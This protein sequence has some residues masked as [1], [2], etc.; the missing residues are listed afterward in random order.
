MKI[1]EIKSNQGKTKLIVDGYIYGCEKTQKNVIRWACEYKK[2]HLCKGRVST[3]KLQN[4]HKIIKEPS[5]HNHAPEASRKELLKSNTF[6]KTKAQNTAMNPIQIITNSVVACEQNCRVYLPGTKSQQKKIK[7]VRSKNQTK[8][9]LS[10]DDINIPEYLKYVESQQFLIADKSFNGNN[11]ILMFTSISNMQLLSKST[12]WFMDGTF[13]CCPSFLCQL[14]TIHAMM[15]ENNIVPLVFGLMSNKS[16]NA[17]YEFFFEIF[18]YACENNIHLHPKYIISDFEK[19]SINAIKCFLPDV[20]NK[21]CYFHFGQIIWRRIQTEKLQTKYG[22]DENFSLKMRMLKCLSLLNVND[23][24]NYYAVLKANF[25]NDEKKIGKW[26]EK[27]YMCSR[28]NAKY[29]VSFWSVNDLINEN[30]PRTQNNVE[31]WHRR[32]QFIIDKNNY[33]LYKLIEVLQ[34]EYLV[35][36]QK[37]KK[38]LAGEKIANKRAYMKTYEKINNVLSDKDNREVL[39]LLAGLAQNV[40]LC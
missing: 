12:V 39:E 25:S 37:I 33:G 13:K 38:F 24:P 20:I 23:I 15:D 36:D 11:R 32:L 26:F 14:F 9:P 34:Q 7:R 4:K 16:Q 21:G 19:A 31:S 5:T 8:E 6:V 35:V 18:K 2:K 28:A 40:Q 1:E 30:L 27:N 3:T 29:P 17:Y 10:I 22:T